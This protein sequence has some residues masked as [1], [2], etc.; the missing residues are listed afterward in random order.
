[1]TAPAGRVCV[2]V[3]GYHSASTIERCL[4]SVLTDAAVERLVVVDNASGDDTA[5]IVRVLAAADPR[6]V[7]IENTENRGF[8]AACNQAAG[9]CTSAYVLF[10]NPDAFA[11]NGAVGAFARHLDA[12]PDVG[13]LGCRVVDASG[14]PCGPQLRREPT[15]RRSLMSST[16]LSRLERR[17]RVFEGVQAPL[18]ASRPAAMPPEHAPAGRD[19]IHGCRD[20][21]PAADLI[22][23]DAVNGAAMIVRR[24]A[25]EQI[26]GFDERFVLH[27]EDLDLCRRIR[28]D[29]WRVA[30]A[31]GVAI[32]HIGGVSSRT[33]PLWVEWQKTRSL[34]RY[35]RIHEPQANVAVRGLVIAGLALRF[36]ARVPVHAWRRIRR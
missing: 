9:A 17:S 24:E 33:R 29:G 31:S 35:F 6:I 16:G 4:R 14:A 36:A 28:D 20:D 18:P 34:W 26:G 32:Q 30:V 8:G 10:L 21:Q 22:D 25:F 7:L 1:M 2:C 15:W 3:V 5:G 11:G 19:S 12:A 13:L 27:A 23:A